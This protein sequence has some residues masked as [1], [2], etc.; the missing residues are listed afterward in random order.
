MN[1]GKDDDIQNT[2]VM[3]VRKINMLKLQFRGPALWRHD[4]DMLILPIFQ[5]LLAMFT[6]EKLD[7]K[8]PCKQDEKYVNLK[9]SKDSRQVRFFLFN[10]LLFFIKFG[11]S[12]RHFLSM[13]HIWNTC[14]RNV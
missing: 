3:I 13:T 6:D 4:Q 14:K 10:F 5:A 2:L 9:R 7:I 11:F 12:K 8:I 1:I